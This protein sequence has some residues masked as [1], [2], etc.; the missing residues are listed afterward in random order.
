M[1]YRKQENTDSLSH[2]IKSYNQTLYRL[3]INSFFIQ[4]CFGENYLLFTDIANVFLSDNEVTQ[5]LC[6]SV[7]E[8]KLLQI[9]CF[10][11][12]NSAKIV[13]KY[14]YSNGLNFLVVFLYFYFFDLKY[15]GISE[16]EKDSYK[17]ALKDYL[18]ISQVKH[19]NRYDKAIVQDFNSKHLNRML[20]GLSIQASA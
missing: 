13:S 12:I 9:E 7:Q 2:R 3:D 4:P 10:N 17:K 5:E 1:S 15:G 18:E 8:F 16:Y 14:G 19:L 20:T 6:D 11:K